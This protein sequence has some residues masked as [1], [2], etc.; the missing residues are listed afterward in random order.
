MTQVRETPYSFATCFIETC[1]FECRKRLTPSTIDSVDMVVSV[2]PN[3]I[4]DALYSRVLR[5]KSGLPPASVL[6][7]MAMIVLLLV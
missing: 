4:L 2:I 7:S 3:E 5:D 1:G 6:K